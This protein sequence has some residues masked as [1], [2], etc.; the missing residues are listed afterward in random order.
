VALIASHLAIN[1]AMTVGMMPITG[2]P[3]PFVSKGGSFLVVCFAA[4]ALWRKIW[5]ERMPARR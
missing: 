4:V 1:T 3:L 5:I 2:L